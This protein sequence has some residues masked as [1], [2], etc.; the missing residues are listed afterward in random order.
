MKRTDYLNDMR[1][2]SAI[3]ARRIEDT[4]EKQVGAL[5]LKTDMEKDLRQSMDLILSKRLSGLLQKPYLYLLCVSILGD[6]I[7]EQDYDSAAAIE[8]LNIATYQENTA[9][10][11]KFR[12]LTHLQKS[13]QYIC[14]ALTR[15]WANTLLESNIS[16]RHD[17]LRNV[18][19]L[20]STV[21]AKVNAGQI[22]DLNMT[23]DDLNLSEEEYL[24]KYL[25]RCELL[26]GVFNSKIAT[27]AA[28]IHEKDENLDLE[29][30]LKA[31][32]IGLQ[33]TNDFGDNIFFTTDAF[34]TRSYQSPFS[35]LRNG[36]L[37]YPLYI[38][39]KEKEDYIKFIS[40]NQKMQNENLLANFGTVFIQSS[41]MEKTRQ[42]IRGFYRKAIS[43]FQ[44]LERSKSRDR[45]M[46]LT[47][48]LL[49]NKYYTEVRLQR[50]KR[51]EQA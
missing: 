18:V 7:N 45:L 47:S 43:H 17:N 38:F 40:M 48:I 8:L 51:R 42:L 20:V 27:I 50:D 44:R 3:V 16:S 28:Q 2:S 29:A 4:V 49:W 24:A 41:A 30:G 34:R 12:T 19:N 39:L 22:L 36:R 13:R 33:I 21:Y 26:S 35:D 10:D 25:R 6:E 11:S 15:E 23:I 14:A 32:G 31:F 46:T 9:I 5:R 1:Q 37:T